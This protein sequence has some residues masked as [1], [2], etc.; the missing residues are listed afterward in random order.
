MNMMNRKDKARKEKKEIRED[1]KTAG[2]FR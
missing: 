2:I 1:M